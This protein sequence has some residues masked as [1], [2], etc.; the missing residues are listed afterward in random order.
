MLMLLYVNQASIKPD[1]N[2][3]PMKWLLP[4]WVSPQ[5]K[6]IDQQQMYLFKRNDGEGETLLFCRDDL[7]S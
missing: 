5:H 2:G 7:I 3:F 1:H 4:Y 6:D